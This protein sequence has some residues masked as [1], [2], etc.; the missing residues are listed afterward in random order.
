MDHAL[1]TP[2]SKNNPVHAAKLV[3][4]L[5]IALLAGSV[6]LAYVHL[7]NQ[8][9]VLAE[10]IRRAE[11]D[12]RDVQSRNDVLLASVAG[13]SSRPMLQKRVDDG[14]LDVVAIPVDKIARLTPPAE[15]PDS[16]VIRT[17]LNAETVR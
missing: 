3:K 8:Q 12:I 14:L 15:A 10:K 6:G 13:L 9:F 11:R 16:T 5:L 4:F 17:A 1:Q 2:A 7:K